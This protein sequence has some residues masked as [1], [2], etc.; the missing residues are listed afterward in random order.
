M[1]G[2][3]DHPAPGKSNSVVALGTAGQG[4][5]WTPGWAQAEGLGGNTTGLNNCI[6]NDWERMHKA[7]GGGSV[8]R[9]EGQEPTLTSAV[10]LRCPPQSHHAD[11]RMQR[12]QGHW[13]F[14]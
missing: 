3:D 13:K 1:M 5:G 11:R 12:T 9:T 8:G 2:V 10:V 14:I 7:N 4:W 6:R